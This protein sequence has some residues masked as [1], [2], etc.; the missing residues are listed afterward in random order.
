MEDN[1]IH[2]KSEPAKKSLDFIYYGNLLALQR[3]S[4]IEARE[5][6]QNGVWEALL[7][8]ISWLQRIY[9]K[10]DVAKCTY[11][12]N[13]EG[14]LKDDLLTDLNHISQLLEYMLEEVEGAL[15]IPIEK[16]A[17]SS[18]GKLFEVMI[19]Q[20][21]VGMFQAKTFIDIDIHNLSTN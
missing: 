19:N 18:N 1:N 2:I 7:M 20:V 3:F 21:Y 17:E 12:E 16:G 10:F 13:D 11:A 9:N 6:E 4:V 14:A 5:L 15:L 8:N